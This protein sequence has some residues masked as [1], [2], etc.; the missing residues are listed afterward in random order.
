[1]GGQKISEEGGGIPWKRG[2]KFKADN[3]ALEI[4]KLIKAS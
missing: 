4:Y 3:C 2:Y 1:M